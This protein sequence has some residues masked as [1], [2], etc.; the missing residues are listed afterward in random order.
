MNRDELK[1]ICKAN[2]IYEYQ[3]AHKM[4]I[5]EPTFIRWLR[6]P[7]TSELEQRIMSAIDSI[8]EDRNRR[9]GDSKCVN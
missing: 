5:S 3:I 4:G 9:E 7:I 2:G 6:V 1:T 8:I